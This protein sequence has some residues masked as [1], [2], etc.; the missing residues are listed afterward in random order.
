M[1]SYGKVL[2]GFGYS[3]NS[4]EHPSHVYFNTFRNGLKALTTWA[5]ALHST[6]SHGNN[7]VYVACTAIVAHFEDTYAGTA[8]GL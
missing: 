8:N 5:C 1:K 3:T 2:S 7:S 6:T 4:D